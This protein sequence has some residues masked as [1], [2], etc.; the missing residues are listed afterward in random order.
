[1]CEISGSRDVEYP[2]SGDILHRLVDGYL[3]FRGTP[4]FVFRIEELKMEAA[5][6]FETVVPFYKPHYVRSQKTIIL[7][8]MLERN[9]I[10]LLILMHRCQALFMILIEN[11]IWSI[12]GKG[13]GIKSYGFGT[14]Y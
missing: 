12:L 9:V 1:M 6:H 13:E 10:R 11:E 2:V 7:S 5:G 8:K 14:G 3:H 4:A